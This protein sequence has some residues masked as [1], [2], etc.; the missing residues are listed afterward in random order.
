MAR[1][2]T[3]TRKA[4]GT[5]A[6]YRKLQSRRAQADRRRPVTSATLSSS[7]NEPL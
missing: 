4:K 1:T 5:A 3:G 7:L 6:Q 2:R